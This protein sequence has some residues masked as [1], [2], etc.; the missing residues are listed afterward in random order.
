[1]TVNIQAN[2]LKD[3][4]MQLNKTKY[5]S[6]LKP[7]RTLQE[8]LYIGKYILSSAIPMELSS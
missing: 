2:K 5:I 7:T 8:Q 3:K 1:M 6:K 4:V